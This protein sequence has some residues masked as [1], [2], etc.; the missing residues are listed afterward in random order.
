M[1][2]Y[3]LIYIHVYIHP[4]IIL[5]HTAEILLGLQSYWQNQIIRYAFLRLFKTAFKRKFG[6]AWII[7]WWLHRPS[8]KLPGTKELAVHFMQITDHIKNGILY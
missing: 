3:V 6:F 2:Q 1:M 4:V 8:N 5:S 7:S